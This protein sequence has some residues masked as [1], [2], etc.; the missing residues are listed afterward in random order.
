MGK[1]KT[2]RHQDVGGDRSMD[3]RVDSAGAEIPWISDE[4]NRAQRI[5]ALAFAGGRGSIE[6]SV[7]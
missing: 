6:L 1:N 4:E 7:G 5:P 2:R 3:E